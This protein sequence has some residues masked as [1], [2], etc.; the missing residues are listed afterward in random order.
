MQT[1]KMY[2]YL[3]Y[4]GGMSGSNSPQEQDENGLYHG[5]PSEAYSTDD[6][7]FDAIERWLDGAGAPALQF[8]Y[9]EELSNLISEEISAYLG[10]A[11][12]AEETAKMLQSRVSIYLAEQN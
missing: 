8:A 2:Y 11:R 1:E 5:T 7:D 4:D 9:P 10:G 3:R 6:I 12:S